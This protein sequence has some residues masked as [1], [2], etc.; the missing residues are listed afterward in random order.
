MKKREREDESYNHK[1]CSDVIKKSEKIILQFRVFILLHCSKEIDVLNS[2][3]S[4]LSFLLYFFFPLFKHELF[5]NSSFSPKLIRVFLKWWVRLCHWANSY[6]QSSLNFTSDILTTEAY[7]FN[8]LG[9][10]SL[11]FT[12]TSQENEIL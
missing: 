7:I 8:L 11:L 2:N 3:S 5:G 10:V 4:L 12:A 1:N 6:Q 9:S